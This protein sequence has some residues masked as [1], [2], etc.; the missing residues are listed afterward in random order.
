M[1]QTTRLDLY[2]LANGDYANHWEVPCN[3]NVQAID[4]EFVA[5]ATELLEIPTEEYAGQLAGSAG[6][7]EERLNIA[8]DGAGAIRFNSGD[9]EKSCHEMDGFETTAINT[10]LANVDRREFVN[11][12]LRYLQQNVASGEYLSKVD[13][14][15][16]VVILSDEEK[17]RY[18]DNFAQ[19]YGSRLFGFATDCNDPEVNAGDVLE[20]KPMGW[21]S[22]GGR[23]FYHKNTS[24]YTL[25][26]TTRWSLL[27]SQEP[28]VGATVSI[29]TRLI[30]AYNSGACATG[31]MTISDGTFH[32]TNIGAISSIVGNNDWQPEAFQILRVE[33]SAGVYE[34]YLIKSITDDDHI[35]IYGEF[36]YSLVGKSWWVLDYTI[37]CVNLVGYTHSAANIKGLMNSRYFYGNQYLHTHGLSYDIGAARF[38][39][40][41]IHNAANTMYA[42][43]NKLF[44]DMTTQALASAAAGNAYYELDIGG[45]FNISPFNVKKMSVLCMEANGLAAGA[46]ATF[47]FAIDPMTYDVE[48]HM[49]PIVHPEIVRTLSH[50]AGIGTIE[51]WFDE[52]QESV[53][54]GGARI[55]HTYLRVYTN[56]ETG[57][58]KW[59]KASAVGFTR[60]WWGVLIEYA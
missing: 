30:R 23:L 32:A 34:E 7:L 54:P 52:P 5:L 1:E 39:A 44:V 47:A 2:K 41:R 6:S 35:E 26:G 36:T 33:I 59:C 10:R 15:D 9:L 42:D 40:T 37:P 16:P 45:A 31:S 8:M 12:R 55:Q 58:L 14:Y 19:G 38:Y 11:A 51:T 24:Y 50:I 3:A 46:L 4:D 21:C 25:L 17:S 29:D 60:I 27:L 57:A 13:G 48:T 56:D 18:A 20:I 49:I 22:I 28:V 43:P 53:A